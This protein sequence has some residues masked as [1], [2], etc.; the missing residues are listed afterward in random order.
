MNWRGEKVD[1]LKAGRGG[2]VAEVGIIRVTMWMR[3]DILSICW[4]LEL[5]GLPGT[6]LMGWRRLRRQRQHP[7]CWVNDQTLCSVGN[8]RI[9]LCI[10]LVCA[11]GVSSITKWFFKNYLICKSLLT[12]VK[13]LEVIG[14][15]NCCWVFLERW[16]TKMRSIM[17]FW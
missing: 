16:L 14:S 9:V 3:R 6:L 5:S 12:N 15:R 2:T 7:T 10:P 13:V 4:K 17:C 8:T 11:P 1:W